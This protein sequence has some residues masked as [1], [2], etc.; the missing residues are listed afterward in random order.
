MA[1]F[2]MRFATLANIVLAAASVSLVAAATL[3]QRQ[4]GTCSSSALG[5]L[6]LCGGA[7]GTCT[8]EGCE[9]TDLGSIPSLGGILGGT[10]LDV[11]VSA[12]E[13]HLEY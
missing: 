1:D 4:L 7:F 9:C 3:E 12:R 6:P 8:G 5:A 13:V 10:G 2:V 11:G